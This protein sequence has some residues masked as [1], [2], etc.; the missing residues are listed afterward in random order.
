MK[1][2]DPSLAL[3]I[4]WLRPYGIL[5]GTGWIFAGLMLYFFLRQ[6]RELGRQRELLREAQLAALQY[7]IQPHFLFNAMNMLAALVLDEDRERPQRAILNLSDFLRATLRPQLKGEVALREELELT[8]KYLSLEQ[9]R[10]AERLT[11]EWELDPSMEEA[12]VP[13]LL[14][15]PLV[16]NAIRH[17]I[18]RSRQGGRI[19]IRTSRERGALRLS[20]EDWHRDHDFAAS[21]GAGVG[22]ENLRKRLEHFY[23]GA[24]ELRMTALANG[25]CV[26]VVIRK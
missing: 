17:S 6:S 26:D 5:L 7:Q 1:P 12:T 13:A 10:L 8:R 3:Q 11:V 20:V 19:W 18:A 21:P 2:Y 23:G 25:M 14:L 9:E 22:L 16:E 4:A 24:A 15:Q